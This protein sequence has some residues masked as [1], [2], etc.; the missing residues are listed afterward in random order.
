MTSPLLALPGAVAGNGVD[1]PV[2]AHY[3]SFNGEQRALESGEG[4]V[5]LSHHDVL[6]I[7]GPDRLTWLHNITTQHLTDLQPGVLTQALILSPQGHVEHEF[8]GTDDGDALTVWTEPGRS[9]ALV[10]FLERM[11]FMM[12]AEITDVTAEHALTWRPVT[13]HRLVPRAELTTYAAAAGPAAG[14][15]EAV[16]AGGTVTVCSQCAARRSLTEA[17]LVDGARIAGAVAFTEL[18]LRDGVRALV[19]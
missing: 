16:R 5:D 12:R 11:K 4:F 13:G 15:V 6:R 2:A 17:D 3:G 10:E 9:G 14:L 19:Y 18:V 8:R 7:E 1:A